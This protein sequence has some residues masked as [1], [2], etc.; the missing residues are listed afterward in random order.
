M[1]KIIYLLILIFAPILYGQSDEMIPYEI[2]SAKIIDKDFFQQLDSIKCNVYKSN[3][4]YYR[5]DFCNNPDSPNFQLEYS[6]TKTDTIL[7]IALQGCSS[8]LSEDYYKVQYNKTIYL[9]SKEANH[10]L[11]KKTYPISM[12]YPKYIGIK[13][14]Y[15]PL[16]LLDY[17]NKKLSIKE[18]VGRW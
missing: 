8:P 14:L 13:D 3:F 10:R 9:I 7:Y 1:K 12:K 18:Y 17:H 4:K 16:L 11:V 6:P 15:S 2:Y 5:I